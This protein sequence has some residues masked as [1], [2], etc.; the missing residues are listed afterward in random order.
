MKKIFKNITAV[1]LTAMLSTGISM[2][3]SMAVKAENDDYAAEQNTIIIEGVTADTCYD[4]KV[5][6]VISDI[7]KITS[8]I[9]NGQQT[10]DGR[11]ESYNLSYSEDGLYN[12]VIEDEVGNKTEIS[13]SIDQTAPVISGVNDGQYYNKKVNIDFTEENI[14]SVTVNETENAE[15][16]NNKNLSISKEGTYTVKVT[17]IVGKST[18][19]KFYIDKT[20]PKI[21][22]VKNKSYY[23]KAVTVKF[24]DKNLYSVKVNGKINKTALKNKKVKISKA[25]KATITVTDKAGNVKTIKFYID[26]TLPVI[27]GASNGEVYNSNVTLKFS[28][29]YAVKSITINGNSLKNTTKSI[30]LNRNGDY[31]VVIN[32]KAGNSNSVGFS[33][34]KRVVTYK[35][36]D[37][38][39]HEADLGGNCPYKLLKKATYEDHT[40][41]FIRSVDI[42]TTL[43]TNA[44]KKIWSKSVSLKV[45]WVGTYDDKGGVNFLYNK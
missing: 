11:S 18:S 12:I 3:F 8:I 9:V 23:Q 36:S 17:D 10:A 38:R 5:D 20:A 28:D 2:N 1:L 42:G 25:G 22:N 4:S 41:F 40:G 45:L 29:N 24:S 44:T 7:N 34:S 33:I 31:A 16:V 19:V 6:L 37:G 21:T 35:G 14:K 15:A 13:F 32:D 27:K 39:T 30:M 43:E 26:K